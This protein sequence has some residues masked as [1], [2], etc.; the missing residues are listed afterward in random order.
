[1]KTISSEL[2]NKLFYVSTQVR[3]TLKKRGFVI[4]IEENGV[5]KVGDYMIKKE[6]NF[7]HI[8]DSSN[9]V[10]IE[11]INLPHTAIMIANKLALGKFL[12]K[13]LIN[14]DRNFG[15]AEF[16]E[17][18]QSKIK[19]KDLEVQEVRE[20]KYQIA[21]HKKERYFNQINKDFKKLCSLV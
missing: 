8:H 14:I 18:L 11:N 10:I 2:W 19:S 21:K 15:Y 13:N 17:R 5:I 7:Y 16:E 4:P 20:M 6:N 12:D 3:D 1:M 9:Y